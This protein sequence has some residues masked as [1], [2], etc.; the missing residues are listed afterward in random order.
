MLFCCV[1]L[2]NMLILHNYL[3]SSKK[4]MEI[5]IS[6]IRHNWETYG[7]TSEHGHKAMRTD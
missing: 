4:Q 2:N 5:F 1:D 3:D 6:T 7:W